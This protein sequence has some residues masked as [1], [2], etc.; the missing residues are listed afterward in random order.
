MRGDHDHLRP[1]PHL[2]AQVLAEV[3]AAL[4]AKAD[5]IAAEGDPDFSWL[6]GGYIDAADYL[7]DVLTGAGEE[8]HGDAGGRTGGV[9]TSTKGG[10]VDHV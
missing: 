3:D 5:E 8:G 7:R 1:L 2:R 9:G 6:S 4:R 10:D